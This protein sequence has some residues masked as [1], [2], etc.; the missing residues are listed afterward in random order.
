MIA[1]VSPSD[2]ATPTLP[3]LGATKVAA[4]LLDPLPPDGLAV[5]TADGNPEPVWAGVEGPTPLT[6]TLHAAAAEAPAAK[7][8]NRAARTGDRCM[9]GADRPT[10]GRGDGV[11]AVVVPA[12]VVGT[13]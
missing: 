2:S 3:P 5:A 8:A 4:W 7:L 13:A 1:L 6:P 12:L 9:A 10:T 11:R